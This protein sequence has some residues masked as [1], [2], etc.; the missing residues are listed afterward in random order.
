MTIEAIKTNIESHIGE[1]VKIIFNGSRNKVEEF[2]AVVKETYPYIFLVGLEGEGKPKTKTFSY[3]DILT[4]VIELH[5]Y[6]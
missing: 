5:F 4:E 6:K 1:R 3:S 2:H